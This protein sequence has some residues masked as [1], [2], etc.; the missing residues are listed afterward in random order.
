MIAAGITANQMQCEPSPLFDLLPG[1]AK[2]FSKSL[3]KKT[4]D[5]LASGLCFRR[6]A[7]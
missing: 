3:S 4:A 2:D 6:Q 7:V 5:K 1:L